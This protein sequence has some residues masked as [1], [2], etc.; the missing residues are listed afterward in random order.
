MDYPKG[1]RLLRI[2]NGRVVP[3]TEE[4]AFIEALQWYTDLTLKA[5]DLSTDPSGQILS[6]YFLFLMRHDFD[7][8]CNAGCF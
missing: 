2:D 8:D 3:A 1:G 4:P 5:Q 6:G 7:D